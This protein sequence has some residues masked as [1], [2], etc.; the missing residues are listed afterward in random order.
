VKK[1]ALKNFEMSIS[2]IVVFVT[3]KSIGET[4]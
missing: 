4:L 3:N 1:I 2:I